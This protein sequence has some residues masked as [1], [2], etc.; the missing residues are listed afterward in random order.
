MKGEGCETERREEKRKRWTE[1]RRGE[2]ERLKERANGKG[3]GEVR[4][5]G[6]RE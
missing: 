1:E 6:L 4:M 3:D 5:N 2:S